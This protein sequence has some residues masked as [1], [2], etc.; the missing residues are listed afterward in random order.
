MND[1]LKSLIDERVQELGLHT[2]VSQ[3]IVPTSLP[4]P[5]PCFG[6]QAAQGFS[7]HFVDFRFQNGN[8]VAFAYGELIY[9]NFEADESRLN[10]NFRGYIVLLYGRNLDTELYDSLMDC[11]V[12][13]I[14]EAS[15]EQGTAADNDVCVERIEIVSP[16]NG[17]VEANADGEES[18]NSHE[19]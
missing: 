12:R 9:V 3:P 11:R 14:A 10:L 7:E 16:D 1:K 13:W 6:I 8:R 18:S 2:S 5:E 17:G 4:N 19:V 15:Q